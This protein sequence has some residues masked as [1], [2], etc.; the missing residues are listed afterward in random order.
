MPARG[1]LR[2]WMSTYRVGGQP[3]PVTYLFTS[4]GCTSRCSFCSIWPQRRGCFLQRDVDSV[5]DEL[6]A[7][8]DYGIVRFADANTVVDVEWMGR[9]LD[10][11]EAEG[12]S[13]QLVMDLR[14]D[15]AA[16][17]PDLIARLAR[18]GLKVVITGVES[19]RADELKRYNKQ[20]DTQSI[21]DGI[22]VFHDCDVLLRA[23]YVID[24]DYGADDFAALG[25]FAGS[26]PT[27][28]AGYTILTP[29]PGTPLYSQVKDRI[30]D[31]DLTRYNF[32]N[33]VLPTR[34]PL[35][36]FY[37]EVGGLWAIRQGDHVIS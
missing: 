21:E 33:C 4:L 12:I 32:F 10:R 28:Y 7:L 1:H 5:I 30:V 29:L 14:L 2:P 36:R 37:Q 35:D 23:N 34:M 6:H 13:K 15:T 27:A 9:L 16:A 22:A 11:I 20:L 19:P 31:H 24:P 26:H 3:E 25:D 17:H 8:D 18:N